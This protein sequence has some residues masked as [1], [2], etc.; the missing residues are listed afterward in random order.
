VREGVKVVVFGRGK[1]N[2]PLREGRI[3]VS[4]KK[5]RRGEERGGILDRGKGIGS[6]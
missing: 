3:R 4:K 6:W 1:E 2:F 5:G